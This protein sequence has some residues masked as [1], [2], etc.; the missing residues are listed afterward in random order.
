MNKREE[1]GEQPQ[2]NKNIISQI[3][4]LS[5]LAMDNHRRCRH[6][7]RRLPSPP[8]ALPPSPCLHRRSCRE[9]P[10]GRQ[11]TDALGRDCPTRGRPGDAEADR[12][13]EEEQQEVEEKILE[14]WVSLE[15]ASRRL[16]PEDMAAPPSP[17]ATPAVLVV[18]VVVGDY[19]S[20]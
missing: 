9:H 10:T 12:D 5:P 7:R 14:R 16:G 20:S 3:P 19:V 11:K 17:A 8:M 1:H 18:V 15:E 4:I 13:E 6:R 2:H